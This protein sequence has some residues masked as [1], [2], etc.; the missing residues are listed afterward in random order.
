MPYTKISLLLGYLRTSV[1]ILWPNSTNFGF[2]PCSANSEAKAMASLAVL[3]LCVAV[4]GVHV[5]Q[6]VLDYYLLQISPCNPVVS[7]TAAAAVTRSLSLPQLTLLAS[8]LFI[9]KSRRRR[10]PR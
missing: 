3:L 5:L 8:Y 4:S 6:P 7:A 10:H 2:T 1:R 9:S